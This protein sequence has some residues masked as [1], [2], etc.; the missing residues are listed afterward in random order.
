MTEQWPT[1]EPVLDAPEASPAPSTE[2][3]VNPATG[4][5]VE[6]ADP[7][8]CARFYAALGVMET[9]IK[10]AR[11]VV[12][13]ALVDHARQYGGDTMRIDAAEIKIGHPVEIVWNL[14]VLRELRA[15][16]LPEAR[17]QELVETTVTEKVKATVAKQIAKAN[18][19]YAEIIERA[20]TRIPKADTVSVALRTEGT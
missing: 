20:E 16:G 4:E 12:R 1:E 17:W 2:L 14:E 10:D 15:A 3:A 8:A 11:F 13:R 7:N 9:K 19:A 18:S 5:I 6:L